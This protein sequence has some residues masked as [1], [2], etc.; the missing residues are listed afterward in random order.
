M[1][2]RSVAV[3]P[4][5][6]NIVYA[7]SNEAGIFKSKDG[8]ITWWT[9]ADST[10]AKYVGKIEVRYTSSGE[11]MI[12][13]RCDRGVLRYKSTNPE[14]VSSFAWEWDVIK[15]GNIRDLVVHATDSSMLYASVT[16]DGIYYTQYGEVAKVET[17][18]GDHDWTKLEA[19]LPTI[20][21]Q[22]EVVLDIHKIYGTPYAGIGNP[23]PGVRFA[24]YRYES[25]VEDGTVKQEWR[26]IKKYAADPDGE[27]SLT[28]ELDDFDYNAYI[29]VVPK[30]ITADGTLLRR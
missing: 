3:D 23:E 13:V 25:W 26:V 12:Y 20:T 16:G 18:P 15:Q 6:P 9:F 19:G 2:I 17:T 28:A 27:G 22:M 1:M 7:G 24:I 5:A 14:A 10:I 29:R 11:V 30:E 21:N 8:G 4:K